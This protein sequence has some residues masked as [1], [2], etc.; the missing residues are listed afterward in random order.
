MLKPS[1]KPRDASGVVLRF[2]SLSQKNQSYPVFIPFL[3]SCSVPGSRK[4]L[5]LKSDA[6]SQT[7]FLPLPVGGYEYFG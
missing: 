5:D 7:Y 1:R 2:I 6:A 3:F 4:K